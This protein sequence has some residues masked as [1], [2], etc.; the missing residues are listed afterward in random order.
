MRV[1]I[2]MAAIAAAVPFGGASAQS[3]FG[4]TSLSYYN[5]VVYDDDLV[6][7]RAP[8]QTFLLGEQQTSF[9]RAGVLREFPQNSPNLIGSDGRLRGV[10]DRNQ[11]S[12]DLYRGR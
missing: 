2:A 6:P 8:N 11:P 7:G 12:T 3:V 1:T 4:D 10:I 9:P 5:G